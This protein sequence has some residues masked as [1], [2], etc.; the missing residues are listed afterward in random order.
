MSQ[1]M[2]KNFLF[3]GL[4]RY[5]LMTL[6]KSRTMKIRLFVK[7]LVLALFASMFVSSPA[8]A[9]VCPSSMVGAGTSGDP[10]QIT[11]PAQLQAISSGLSLTYKLMNNLDMTGFAW[12]NIG[13]DSYFSPF[14]GIL[15]GNDHTISNWT[16]KETSGSY[17]GFFNY[18]TGEIKN[19]KVVNFTFTVESRN[20]SFVG[21]FIGILNGGLYNVSLQG[22]LNVTRND[23][24]YLGGIAGRGTGYATGV[25]ADIDINGGGSTGL[26]GVVGL[27][28][29]GFRFLGS[30]YR[31]TISNV[32]ST[33][34]NEPFSAATNCTYASTSY[35]DS[36][37]VGIPQSACSTN[38]KSTSELQTPTSATGIYS[39]WTQLWDFGNSSEYPALTSFLSNPGTPTSVTGV[40]G[41]ASVAVSWTA[42]ANTGGRSIST[43]TA[44]STPGGFTCSSS[45]TS[46]TVNGLT[47]GT[48]YSF[49]VTATTSFG[50]SSTSIS[51][52]AATPTAP[53]TPSQS[54]TTSGTTSTPASVS[55]NVPA[56]KSANVKRNK[57]YSAKSVA[58]MLSISVPKKATV[59]VSVSSASKAAKTCSKSGT[60]VAT[61]KKLGDCSVTVTVQPARIK[62]VKQAP[63]VTSGIL[64]VK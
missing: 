32:D 16:S 54:T 17:E 58:K 55:E 14:S 5:G 33:V 62:G 31:G 13:G 29:S 24:A 50:T 10:C 19:L 63:Q 60:N 7:A 56:V 39:T 52:A 11:T 15:D 49:A 23:A 4:Q 21:G 43:Y 45:T 51:S 46:C 27:Y 35:Y 38:G 3:E 37:L 2:V 25:D 18:F 44:T 48:S 42:P 6:E 30:I 20:T 9:A 40:A 1:Q 59:K 26:S 8:N 47:N 36:S 22:T 64:A 57:K 53:S 41:D 12:T 61:K 34:A 28:E